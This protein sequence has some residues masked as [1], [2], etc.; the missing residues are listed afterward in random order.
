MNERS[1]LALVLAACAVLLVAGMVASTKV[2]DSIVAAAHREATDQ[3]P[4]PTPVALLPAK[5][6]ASAKTAPTKPAPAHA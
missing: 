5:A 2:T 6:P 1:L 4:V 3:S